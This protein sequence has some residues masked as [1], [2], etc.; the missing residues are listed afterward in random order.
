MVAGVPRALSRLRV[1][2]VTHKG[3]D[4]QVS[5]ADRH[6]QSPQRLLPP[7]PPG[8]KSKG[9][10][11]K[12]SGGEGVKAP[13]LEDPRHILGHPHLCWL[14]LYQLGWVCVCVWAL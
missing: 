12:G 3:G 6:Q 8:A 1:E 13:S 5:G 9:I 11:W 14:V 7:P 4:A 2:T 10:S